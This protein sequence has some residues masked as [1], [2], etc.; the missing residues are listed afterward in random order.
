LDRLRHFFGNKGEDGQ[1][2]ILAALTLVVV[3]GFAALA[4]DV[5]NWLHTKT[6]LQADADAMA[7]AGAQMLNGTQTGANNGMQKARDYA[8]LNAVADGEIVSVVYTQDCDGNAV[9]DFNRITVRLQRNKTSFLAQMFGVA[10]ADIPVCAT[11]GKLAISGFGATSSNGG[12]RP[13]GLEEQ[14]MTTIGYGS[15]ITLKFD[16]GAESRTCNASQGNYG[17]L[18]IDGSGGSTYETTIKNGSKA[19]I[20]AQRDPNCTNFNFITE[21]GNTI[22]P[23]K[24]GIKYIV[25]NTPPACNAWEKVVSWDSSMSQAIINP[26]CDPWSS[27]YNSTYGP[28][29]TSR[30]LVIPVVSGMWASGGTNPVIVKNFAIVFLEGFAGGE[31]ACTGNNCDIHARFIKAAL[32]LPNAQRTEYYVGADISVAVLR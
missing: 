4:I 9:S 23:T 6:K 19:P 20:C 27:N 17:A 22:G 32:H 26:A 12:V 31:N 30:L 24:N 21:T 10:D 14:C 25:D 29:A 2:V 1:I 16:S 13:F 15:R 5:G 3:L 8:P 11:A 28:D 7:L 18:R